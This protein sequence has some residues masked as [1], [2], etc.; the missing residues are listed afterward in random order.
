MKT[1][2]SLVLL[3]L[4]VGGCSSIDDDYK[5]EGKVNMGTAQ[6]SWVLDNGKHQRYK[7][8]LSTES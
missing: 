7:Q 5:T 8:S 2:L 6:A 3:S 1:L 4:V